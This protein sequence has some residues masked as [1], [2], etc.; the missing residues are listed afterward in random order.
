MNSFENLYQ[1]CFIINEVKTSPYASAHPSFNSITSKMRGSGLSSA[2]LDT[3]RFIRET[4]YYLDILNDD[5]LNEIKR[6]PGFTGKKQAMLKFLKLKQREINQRKDEIAQKVEETLDSFISSMG[7][8]RGREE[9]Y[10]IQATAQEINKQMKQVQSGKNMETAL[11][12]IVSNEKILIQAAIYKIIDGIRSELGEPGFDIENEA[13]EEVAD[14]ADNITTLNDFKSF[15]KQ[16]STEPGYEKIAAYLSS[17]IPAL[18]DA[19]KGSSEDSEEYEDNEEYD[20]PDTE[21]EY[22]PGASEEDY[23]SEE[24]KKPLPKT[25]TEAYMSEAIKKSRPARVI[26][27]GMTFK[28]RMKPRNSWQLQELRNY[29]L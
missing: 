4:L 16:L 2:P 18:T 25:Y 11:N 15:I 3:I 28:Q 7:A 24:R 8:N 22:D 19:L 14:Y 13:L 27:E 21:T 23:D 1:K 6:A 29:G 10:A 5:E 17:S 26:E 20:D 12:D 9:T